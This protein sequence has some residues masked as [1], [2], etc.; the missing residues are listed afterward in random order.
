MDDDFNTSG[1][2]AAIFELITSA[3]KFAAEHEELSDKGRAVL[4]R[5]GS[6]LID[7]CQI[8][9]IQVGK[10][11]VRAEDESLVNDLM[12]LIIAVRQ[13]ARERKDWS[14]A[15]EIRDGLAALGIKLEDTREGTI[16]KME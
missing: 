1:A 16:W 9:G 14:T 11:A 3:N 12:K 5:V 2:I 6:A 4:G 10:E 15:D 8:L 7:L 13:R